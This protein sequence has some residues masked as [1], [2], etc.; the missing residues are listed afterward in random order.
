MAEVS[1]AFDVAERYFA[2]G[3][4]VDVR[5]IIGDLGIEYAEESRPDSIS[6]LIEKSGDGYRIVVNANHSSPRRRFSAAHELA[7]Y[8]YHRDLIGDGIVD[9]VAYRTTDLSGRYRNAKIL[10]EHETQAN[11]FAS[12]VLMPSALIEKLQ[13]EH[14][15]DLNDPDDVKKLARLLDV[16]EQALRIRLKLD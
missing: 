9:D 3:A 5:G 14:G 16:S 13:L 1:N 4:P 6:G 12:V 2:K 8:V 10:P 15:L 11:R 7:H